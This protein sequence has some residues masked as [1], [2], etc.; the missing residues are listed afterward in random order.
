MFDHMHAVDNKIDAMCDS[1]RE[2]G[3]RTCDD[4]LPELER[5][6]F[7][8]LEDLEKERKNESVSASK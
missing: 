2:A 5:E 4:A 6:E 1:M 3:L 7:V 8:S